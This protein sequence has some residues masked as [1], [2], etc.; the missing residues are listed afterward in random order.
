VDGVL[1]IQSD[2]GIPAVGRT[3]DELDLPGVGESVARNCSNK[4][5]MQSV[6]EQQG[7]LSWIAPDLS[8]VPDVSS[9]HLNMVCCKP[10]T[11]QLR[12]RVETMSCA[13]E[14]RLNPGPRYRDSRMLRIVGEIVVKGS[15]WRDVEEKAR[16]IKDRIKISITDDT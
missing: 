12:L 14:K 7:T 2:D 16:R 13:F 3:V 8:P 11:Y 1:T 4:Y 10:S 15:S 6:F 5:D 9:L